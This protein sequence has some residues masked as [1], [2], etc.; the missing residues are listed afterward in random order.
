MKTYI[1]LIRGINVGGHNKLPMAELRVALEDVGLQKVR[2]YIQSGNVI[3]QSPKSVLI[4]LET[5]ISKV[6]ASIF[7]FQ[8]PV[9]VK[10]PNAIKTILDHCP[11][12][13]EEKEKSH[14]IL[15]NKVPDKMLVDQVSSLTFEDEYYYIIDDCLYFYSSH[16]YGR[17]KF[18][19]KT[20]EKKLQVVGT[21]RNY[22]TMLKLLALSST[23]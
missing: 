9:I 14:F 22:K 15:L 4:A 10:T 3:F 23:E 6:I 17:T 11:F 20:F 13:A 5:I 16:G 19:M 21:S 18:N 12:S 2:T 7:G 1:A 8:V